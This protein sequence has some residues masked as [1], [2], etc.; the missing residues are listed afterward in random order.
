[1]AQ[2]VGETAAGV[3]ALACTPLSAV[4]GYSRGLVRT[5]VIVGF[6]HLR[7][8]V[9][10]QGI[11]G[12]GPLG[13]ILIVGAVVTA[14][15]GLVDAAVYGEGALVVNLERSSVEVLV[16]ACKLLVD[17]HLGN[18]RVVAPSRAGDHPS[19]RGA[20]EAGEGKAVGGAAGE[21]EVLP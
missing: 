17:L 2:K 10:Q 3:P 14:L 18:H 1:M 7:R 6:K 15:D 19:E 16:V 8:V 13:V 5:A 11:V 4:V 12:D 21:A 9:Y 20:A